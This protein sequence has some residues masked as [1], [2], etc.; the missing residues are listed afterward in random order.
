MF[1]KR[2]YTPKP[3]S[4]PSVSRYLVLFKVR[5]LYYHG[6]IFDGSCATLNHYLR[7]CSTDA[8]FLSLP[9]T[10]CLAGAIW[11]CSQALFIFTRHLFT[12]SLIDVLQ[13]PNLSGL[14]VTSRSVPRCIIKNVDKTKKDARLDRFHC[15]KADC[16]AFR[17]LHLSVL[18][19]GSKLHRSS[20]NRQM[21]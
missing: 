4:P 16:A 6:K 8:V 9:F 13:S 20:W 18:F 3:L 5:A 2:K 14:S 7:G 12:R 15:E 1:I 11:L 21:R 19:E 17:L 10:R